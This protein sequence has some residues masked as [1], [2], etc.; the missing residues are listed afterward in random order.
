MSPTPTPEAEPGV[1]TP[2]PTPVRPPSWFLDSAWGLAI[3][4]VVLVLLVFSASPFRSDR[5]FIY[6]DF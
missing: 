2:M 6:I 3:A 1:A 4:F 5:G